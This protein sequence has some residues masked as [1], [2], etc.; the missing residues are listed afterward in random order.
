MRRFNLC[1]H[2]GAS[3]TVQSRAC[4]WQ[5][6]GWCVTT[7][8]VPAAPVHRCWARTPRR[9]RDCA[10]RQTAATR[11]ASA[12]NPPTTRGVRWRQALTIDRKYD[13]HEQPHATNSRQRT[14]LTADRVSVVAAVHSQ[15]EILGHWSTAPCHRNSRE[16]IS[17]ITAAW[18]QLLHHSHL[19]TIVRYS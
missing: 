18:L 11:I 19:L 17:S 14:V 4:H 16:P 3:S 15:R 9:T 6:T 8:D 1:L 5:R 12:A 13:D 2:T 10:I 7:S